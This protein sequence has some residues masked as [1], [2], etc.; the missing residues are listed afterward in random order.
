M[1]DRAPL[2]RFGPLQHTSAASR[3]CSEGG[4]P[5]DVSRSGVSAC[6]VRPRFIRDHGR[7]AFAL[8]VFRSSARS[9]RRRSIR[10]T[11][12]VGLP[13]PFSRVA[14]DARGSTDRINATPVALWSSRASAVGES[15]S[16]PYSR[17]LAADPSVRA[18]SRRLL[19][20]PGP[21]HAPTRPF[22]RCSATRHPSHRAALPD[23]R[24]FLPSTRGHET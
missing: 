10:R 19:S 1:A 16:S 7:R 15:D 2:L 23:E 14:C 5:P 13:S 3:A 12:G 20:P 4:R 18:L 9:M 22:A 11:C 24:S 17:T 8:A 6:A 21:G